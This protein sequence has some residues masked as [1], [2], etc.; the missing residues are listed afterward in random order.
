MGDRV[1]TTPTAAKRVIGALAISR[2]TPRR[3]STVG[4]TIRT[5]ESGSSIQ[6][7]AT[8]IDGLYDLQGQGGDLVGQ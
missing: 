4:R 5:R 1:L 7:T 8:P 2:A 3:S 6:S